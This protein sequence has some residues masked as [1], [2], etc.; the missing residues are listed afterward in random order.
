MTKTTT[1]AGSGRKAKEYGGVTVRQLP[2]GN[3]H[4]QVYAGKDADGKRLT[5]LSITNPDPD[6]VGRQIIVFKK[7]RRKPKPASAW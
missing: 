2:S 5:P 4:A 7:N 1:R 3:W 6:E